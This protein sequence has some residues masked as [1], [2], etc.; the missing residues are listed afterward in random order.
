MPELSGIQMVTVFIWK[1][2]FDES[3]FFVSKKL[4]KM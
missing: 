3:I 4:I 1:V 2:S